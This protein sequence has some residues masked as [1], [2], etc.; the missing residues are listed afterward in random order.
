[1]HAQTSPQ[2]RVTSRV[3]A[4]VGVKLYDGSYRHE[5]TIMNLDPSHDLMVVRYVK[6]NSVEPKR[7][8]AVASFWYVRKS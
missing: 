3:G 4:R 8:S 2:S 1:M 5:A 7:L 6:S